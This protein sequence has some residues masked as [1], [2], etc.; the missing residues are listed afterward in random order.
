[1]NI[2][3]NIYDEESDHINIIDTGVVDIDRYKAE[4]IIDLAL[5]IASRHKQGIDA[6][7]FI[8]K[9]M[10]VCEDCV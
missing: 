1:M 8:E 5:E 3:I 10:E 4:E 2:D 7:A 9:L 6:S